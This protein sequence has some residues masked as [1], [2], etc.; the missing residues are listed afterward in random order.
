MC[1]YRLRGPGEASVGY[2]AHLQSCSGGWRVL[3]FP[4]EET[5]LVPTVSLGS[6]GAVGIVDRA[7]SLEPDKWLQMPALLSGCKTKP[8]A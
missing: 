7:W 5:P 8:W 1:F 2:P 3:P 4:K 6:P